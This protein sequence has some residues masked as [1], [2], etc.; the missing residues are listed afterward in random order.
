MVSGKRNA[1]PAENGSHSKQCITAI[2]LDGQLIC[3]DMLRGI[4]LD[5][6]TAVTSYDMENNTYTHWLSMKSTEKA[7]PAHY[8]P[9][10][11]THTN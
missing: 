10:D 1:S 6:V 3:S 9:K 2:S 4:A 8:K 5:S 11:S 7:Q